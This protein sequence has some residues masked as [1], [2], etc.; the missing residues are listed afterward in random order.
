MMTGIFLEALERRENAAVGWYLRSAPL[1]DEYGCSRVL[2]SA[3]AIFAELAVLV[4]Q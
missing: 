3:W 4:L 2:I 1:M